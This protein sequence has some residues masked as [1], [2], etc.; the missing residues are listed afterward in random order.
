[1]Q[2]QMCALLATP[3]GISVIT[4]TVFPQRFMHVSELKRM[5]ADIELDGPTAMIKASSASAAHRSWPAICAPPRRWSWPGLQADGI[6]EVN[7]VYHIDRGYESRRKAQ[8]PRRADRA[9]QS[10]NAA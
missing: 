5:G 3:T 9:G 10:L 1:M 4:E 7:R 6:T 8:R 2:A